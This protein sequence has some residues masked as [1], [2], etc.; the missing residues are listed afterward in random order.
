MECGSSANWTLQPPSIPSASIIRNAEERSIWYSSSVSV[1][2][3]ATTML[4]PVCTPIGS[5]FSILQMVMHVPAPS[6][7]TSYSIS[8]Q[9]TSDRSS[10]HLVDRARIQ[11][12]GDNALQL[13]QGRRHAAAGPSERVCRPHDEGQRH[14]VDEL[15]GLLD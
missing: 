3:G 10:K 5:K 11:T 8:F 15:K 9:P 6:R 12:A 14:V 13:D 2:D 4:S 1:C 7:I